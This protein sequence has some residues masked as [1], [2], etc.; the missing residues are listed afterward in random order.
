M[1]NATV[2]GRCHLFSRFGKVPAAITQMII[3]VGASLGVGAGRAR[4]R[5]HR[6][7]GRGK[8]QKS[9]AHCNVPGSAASVDKW[10][11]GRQEGNEGTSALQASRATNVTME[12]GH[13]PRGPA[14]ALKEGP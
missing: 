9:H 14:N 6:G 13:W 7:R 11:G 4:D 2:N 12:R 5:Q 8:E 3:A 1:G 10:H